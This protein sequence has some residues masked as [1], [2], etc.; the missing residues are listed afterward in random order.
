M[1]LKDVVE[2]GFSNKL[3]S[4]GFTPPNVCPFCLS[5][6]LLVKLFKEFYI[7]FISDLL[8]CS[9]IYVQPFQSFGYLLII[10]DQFLGIA[11]YL[12]KSWGPP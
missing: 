6:S 11:I 5:V 12:C 9:D 2:A 3:S 8:L 1:N 7:L 10:N 4:M